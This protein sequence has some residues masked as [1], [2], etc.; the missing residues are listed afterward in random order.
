[1][2]LEM[3]EQAKRPFSSARAH[4]AAASVSSRGVSASPK[5]GGRLVRRCTAPS[6]SSMSDATTPGTC[7]SAIRHSRSSTFSTGWWRATISSTSRR[8]SSSHSACLR[9]G[10]VQHLRHEVDRP[11]LLVANQRHAQQH[12]HDVPVLVEDSA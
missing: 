11:V 5:P 1:M 6:W 12:P 9:L 3:S 10:D 8:S 7:R 4:S 2:S